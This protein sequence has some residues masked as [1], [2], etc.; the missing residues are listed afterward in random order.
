M[1]DVL[2][3]LDWVNEESVF[4]FKHIDISNSNFK[5]RG[6]HLQASTALENVEMVGL[7]GGVPEDVFGVKYSLAL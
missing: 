2:T 4:V 6:Y 3:E 5:V 1:F 7:L